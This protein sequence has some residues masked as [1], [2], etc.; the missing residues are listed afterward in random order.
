[1]SDVRRAPVLT[2]DAAVQWRAAQRE[3]GRRVAFTNGCFDVLHAGHLALLEGA[4]GAGDALIVALN[5]DASVV[6]LKGAGRPLV[7]EAERA[8]LVA[9]LRCVDGVT[10][11]DEDTPAELIALLIPDVL[12]KGGDYTSATVVGRE[13]VEAAGGRVLIVPLVPDRSTTRLVTRATGV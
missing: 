10:F 8:A 5:T 12:V 4:R 13:I 7:A 9:A 2:R 6:R 1:M 11:F 3:A